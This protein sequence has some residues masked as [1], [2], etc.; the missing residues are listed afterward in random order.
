MSLCVMFQ[1]SLP[2]VVKTNPE[3]FGTEWGPKPEG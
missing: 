3:L 1:F 2:G